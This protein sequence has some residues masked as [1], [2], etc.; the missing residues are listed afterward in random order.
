[1]SKEY[2]YPSIDSNRKILEPICVT[3]GYENA[4]K[5]RL[6]R[7]K[8]YPSQYECQTFCDKVII[9]LLKVNFTIKKLLANGVSRD[10]IYELWKKI[11]NKDNL[12]NSDSEDD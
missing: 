9:D 6:F 10:G 5:N 11:T 1:M 7:D 12:S 8:R 2:W 3:S 4:Y